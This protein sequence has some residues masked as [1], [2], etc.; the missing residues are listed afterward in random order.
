[1]LT[2]LAV[3]ALLGLAGFSASTPAPRAEVV[4]FVLPWDDH[5]PGLTDLSALNSPIDESTRVRADAD[6]HL[7]AGAARLRFLGVNFAGDAPFMPTNK[8]EAVAARLAK[9]GFNSV[10]FHHLDAPWATG[11]GILRYTATRS[12]D[13]NPAQLQ[14]IHA[15]VAALKA[16]GIYSD[17]NLLVGREYRRDDGLGA[18][19]VGMDWKDQHILGC[20][21]TN[22]LALQ[23]EYATGLLTPV[24]PFT[25]LSLAADPAV[26]F[27]EIINENGLLQKWY[28]GALDRLPARYAA[29]LQARWNT[30]LSQRYTTEASL[31]AAWKVLDA[32]L[33]TNLVRNAS[34]TSSTTGW[35]L[36][37][38]EGAAATVLRTTD[39]N[40]A[41]AARVTVTKTGAAGWHVQFNQPGLPIQRDQIY[42]LTF[43]AKADVAT[44]LDVAVMQAHD[45]WQAIGLAR[46]VRLNTSWQSYTNVFVGNLPASG[47]ALDANARVN[48][49]NLG[50][51]LGSTWF[52]NVRL[53]KGGQLGQPPGGT[54]LAQHTLPNVRYA[55]DGYLGTAE[56]RRDWIQCLLDLESTY[57][58]A[59]VQHV[60][61]TCGYRGLIFGTIMA[62]SP[63]TVQSRLDVIDSHAYWQHP[64]FPGT[65]WDPV[66][67][68]LGNRTM[69]NTTNRDNTLPGLSC[70]RLAGKPF[71]VTEYQHPSPSLYGSEG[72]LLLAAQ[73][74]LQDWDGFWLFDYGPG[75]DTV[76]MGRVR[77]FFDT[78]QHP[79]K[80][81][82][83]V[84][85]ANLFRRGDLTPLTNVW[86][87]P[88]TPAQEL[89]AL[90]S[91]AGAWSVFD[92][93]R[94]GVP[95]P[96]AF[97]TR[98]SVRFGAD[99]AGIPG[100]SA[101]APAPTDFAS[102]PVRWNLPSPTNGYVVI[103]TARTKAA[104]GHLR[105]RA[106][107]WGELAASVSPERLPWASLGLTLQRG[108]SF[109]NGSFLVVS[110]SWTE[111]TGQK[112]KDATLSSVGDQ[113][114]TAP[115]LIEVVPFELTLPVPA[116]RVQAWSLD[117]RGQRQA[118][119]LPTAVDAGH[120][121][122]QPP[123][124]S[125]TLWYEIE[126]K[127]P[128]TAANGFELWREQ[129]FTPDER[130]ND[131]I[132][133]PGA[134]PAG[135]GVPNLLKYALGLPAKAVADR[136]RLGS[137]GLTNTAS[138]RYLWLEYARRAELP[139]VTLRML[140]STQLSPWTASEAAETPLDSA[141]TRV[142]A[143]LPA[144]L[145]G[146]ATGFLRAE[147]VEKSR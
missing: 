12:R 10:R 47:P 60:R 67:W 6:G 74:A 79:T 17:I 109:T 106:L 85:A 112:W 97:D 13:F 130:R 24:N 89:A 116:C 100:V 72:P 103:D 122:L 90:A 144:P 96:R 18:E 51:R 95:A 140:S 59:M 133:G 46:S 98:L 138:G 113:W 99:A 21:N 81:A 125:A 7:R 25:G 121:R 68:T 75:Q 104:I 76:G 9:F 143:I 115:T 15:V 77:G 114:G 88:V 92:S 69:V 4:P 145:V 129:E 28:E 70:Q 66:N 30:W 26:A 20:F 63:A 131:A 5:T 55:G 134:D 29:D 101:T 23:Q 14:R 35:V 45:P 93:G 44:D 119:W 124:G 54:S 87:I 32:P 147:V 8:A 94:F 107:R 78:A 41:A 110:S 108:E 49:G 64:V 139:D 57:Y 36:E 42:T 83:V 56:A 22:A 34:F 3:F 126:V 1:M 127:P 33:Q 37:Q 65:P 84:L 52:A 118:A 132:S 62:N 53:Q 71:L 142:R 73:A 91:D 135:D 40:G 38:H 105:G 141:L 146:E 80:L 61:S 58:D 128:D 16:H 39:F 117:A 2:R 137:W 50:T 120:C 31:L 136:R 27:V 111:N 82:N 19:V 11:G 102:L 43:S 123:A 48:F 86:Q